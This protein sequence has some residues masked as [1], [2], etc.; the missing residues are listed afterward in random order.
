MKYTSVIEEV[1]QFLVV[2]F[3]L[4]ISPT[5]SMIL[6]PYILQTVGSW[7]IPGGIEAL[8]ITLFRNYFL[9]FISHSAFILTSSGR[10]SINQL[11]Y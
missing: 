7:E 9:A 6:I 8:F 4:I 2:V 1:F 5:E 11:S 10:S 3:F